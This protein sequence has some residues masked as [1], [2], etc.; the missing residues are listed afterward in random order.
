MSDLIIGCCHAKSAKGVTERRHDA[1]LGIS[2]RSVQIEDGS[3]HPLRHGIIFP[4]A[5]GCM[6]RGIIGVRAMPPIAGLVRSLL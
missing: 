4:G 6:R 5:H 3:Y 1:F 2:E